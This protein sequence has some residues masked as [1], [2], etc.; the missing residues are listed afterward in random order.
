MGPAY[1]YDPVDEVMLVFPCVN[2]AFTV[3]NQTWSYDA[4]A[5]E[6]QDLAAAN[7]PSFRFY[8]SGAYDSESDKFVVFGGGDLYDNFF[9]ETWSY[10]LT[11]NTWTKMP[12]AYSPTP[13]IINSVVYDSESDRII[14]FGGAIDSMGNLGLLNET[15]SYD[16]DTN[17]WARMTPNAGPSERYG[18]SAVYDPVSDLVI[19]FGGVGFSYGGAEPIPVIFDDMWTY[20][21]NTDTWSMVNQLT[22]P[23]ERALGAMAIDPSSR[24]IVL[25]GGAH[26]EVMVTLGD[27]WA[28]Q[29]GAP[30]PEFGIFPAVVMVIIVALFVTNVANRRKAQ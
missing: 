25:Y 28:V 21:L 24:I 14:L 2:A 5:D 13:T 8:S 23:T 12:P 26:E 18:I 22:K 19:T 16:L 11:S 27:T 17:S 3:L 29:L 30:I 15:W 7:S 20:D 4:S 9:N 6:W 10:D 1:A